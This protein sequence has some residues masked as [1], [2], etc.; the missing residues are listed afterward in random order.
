MALIC[1]AVISRKNVKEGERE[2]LASADLFA[3]GEQGVEN[4]NMRASSQCPEWQQDLAR[5]PG[6]G[7]TRSECQLTISQALCKSMV[8]VPL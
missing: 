1:D 2:E 6:V 8:G 3:G 5:Q 4:V 7:V